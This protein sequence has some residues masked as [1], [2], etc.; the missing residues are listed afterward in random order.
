MLHRNPKYFIFMTSESEVFQLFCDVT[1]ESTSS[2]NVSLREIKPVATV[3]PLGLYKSSLK[4]Y[5]KMSL[6]SVFSSQLPHIA[7]SAFS[8]TILTV[9]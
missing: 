2:F 4:M 1:E 9:L 7:A 8:I 3:K 6:F 5:N